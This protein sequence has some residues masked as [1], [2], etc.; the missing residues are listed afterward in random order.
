[1][2]RENVWVWECGWILCV[3]G[4]WAVGCLLEQ[5]DQI[6]SAHE[7]FPLRNVRDHG[8]DESQEWGKEDLD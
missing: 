2:G 3:S 1:M 8:P 7:K 6:S 4:L 5:R